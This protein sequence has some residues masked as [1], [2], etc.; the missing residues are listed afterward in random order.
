MDKHP[1]IIWLGILATVGGALGFLWGIW[2]AEEEQ[3]LRVTEQ[4]IQDE[5]WL[6]RDIVWNADQ[7]ALMEMINARLQVMERNDDSQNVNMERLYSRFEELERS[8][9]A[10]NHTMTYVAFDLG[11]HEEMHHAVGGNE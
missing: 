2:Q 10:Q 5:A 1:V 4:L 9:E 7:L 3:A 11:R 6:E 8:L